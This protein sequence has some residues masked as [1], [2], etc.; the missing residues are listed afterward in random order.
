MISVLSHLFIKNR[1]EYKDAKVRRSYG[2]LCGILGIILN[3]CLCAVK[4][5][6]GTI[7]GSIA[8]TADAFNNLSDA[9]SSTVTLFGFKLAGHE[10][11]SEHPFG[12]GRIEYVSGLIVAIIIILMAWELFKESFDRILHPAQTEI[13]IVVIVIL[14]IS[15]LVK[16]YIASY[17]FRIGK[18]IDSAAMRAT[19]IDSVSD[20]TVTSLV[21]I[22]GIIT[23]LT[24]LKIDGYGGFVVA[25][26]VMWAGISA[27]KETLGPLL[28]QSPSPETVKE[29]EEIVMCKEHTELGILGM[30]DLIVHDYGPGRV[31]ISLDV[32]VSC[33]GDIMELHNIIDDIEND[34]SERF[35]CYVTIHMDPVLL[36]D[37]ETERM[38]SIVESIILSMDEGLSFHDFRISKD[39]R[40]TRLFFDVV[41]PY[42]Y[43]LKDAEV[44]DNITRELKKI[45]PGYECVIYTDKA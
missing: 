9:A 33:N 19:G 18:L 21:L 42:G 45:N 13:N 15:I 26:F 14:V 12:H 36:N 22:C 40:S 3:V 37:P 28:G 10:P 34:I 1:T 5:F 8:I 6:A 29:I 31:I 7:S 25:A 35:G 24:G 11:D 23:H 39:D 2:V 30:H 20:V 43:H 17:N 16:I 44:K 41:I 4:F 38:K 32:E 27:I